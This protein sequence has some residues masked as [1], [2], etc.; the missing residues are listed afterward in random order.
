MNR[1]HAIWL[2][3]VHLRDEGQRLEVGPSTLV[4]CSFIVAVGIVDE[5]DAWDLFHLSFCF[6]VPNPAL[7]A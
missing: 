2:P 6:G 7:L 1:P 5:P 3:F 4:W